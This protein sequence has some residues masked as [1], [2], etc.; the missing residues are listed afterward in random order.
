MSFC[1][2]GG[3]G[4][5]FS[6]PDDCGTWT[7][8]V[9]AKNIPGIG[10]KYEIT[11]LYTPFGPY[12][13]SN[14]GI[15][16]DVLQCMCDSIKEVQSQFSPIMTLISNNNYNISVTEGEPNKTVATIQLQNTGSFAS[17]LNTTA[18]S[19]VP[20][21]ELDPVNINGIP[22]GGIADY[23]V[24]LKPS[25]LNASSSPFIGSINIQNRDD[26]N[27]PIVVSFNVS[28][29]P[30]SQIL[31]SPESVNLT[32]FLQT[33]TSGGTATVVVSNNGPVGSL[34]E[35][36]LTQLSCVSWLSFSPDRGGPLASGENF[37]VNFNLVTAN[38]PQKIGTYTESISV[39]GNSAN[40]SPQLINVT[41][42]VVP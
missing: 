4:F 7:W 15:P 21:L 17:F 35:A 23:Q 42:N 30:K 33:K 39:T 13:V 3:G 18:T 12:S 11:D 25:Q 28:V 16:G 14:I 8:K 22:R 34:L 24:I 6:A 41:L 37:P 36:V 40:N 19:N 27:N 1:I 5:E 31:L 29:F 26:P 38:I 9:Q 32:W 10:Q 20:W 2:T